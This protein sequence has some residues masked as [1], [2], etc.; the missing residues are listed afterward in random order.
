MTH[1]LRADRRRRFVGK[2]TTA[3]ACALVTLLAAASAFAGSWS[4]G[5]GDAGDLVPTAQVPVGAG[6]L[7]LITGSVP[8][9]TDEDLYKICLTGGQTF[10]A[11]T[12][13]QTVRWDTQLFLF[14]AG[15]AGVYA[16]DD[17][18]PFIPPVWPLSI[19]PAGD[20]LTPS[21][22]GVYYL[23]I[24][25]YDNDA[26]SSGGEIFPTDPIPFVAVGPTGPGGG[27]PLSGWTNTGGGN[28]E[29]GTGGV[30]PYEIRL[31][32][33]RYCRQ[34]ATVDIKPEGLP[35]SINLKSKGVIPV[36]ILTTS[37][38]DAT[39]ID[40]MSVC[41]GD[42]ESPAERDCTE[43]HGRGHLEDVDG[44]G[45]IDLVLHFETQETEIDPGD[46]EACLTGS[47]GAGVTVEGC[48]SVNIVNS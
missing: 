10:S 17:A 44:D 19:L 15:G 6:S 13:G 25:S 30:G 42:A 48:D 8:T 43:A 22:P 34:V 45:D 31:T 38:L 27:S 1:H 14:D 4:E 9:G 3:V 23:A 18:A 2:K 21:A 39:T 35:N 28:P 46:T 33:T 24:S 37:D 5:P 41:F 11:T 29:G 16:N 32:G 36:A 26:L 7:D 12:V 20:P 47:A 40:P